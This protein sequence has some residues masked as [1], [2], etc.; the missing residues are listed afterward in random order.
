MQGATRF[1]TTYIDF[2]NRQRIQ[3][4]HVVGISRVNDPKNLKILNY[5]D[6]SLVW[7]CK[8]AD[9]EIDRMRK[10]A[11]LELLVPDLKAMPHFK[12]IFYNMQGLRSHLEDIKCNKNLMECDILLGA[13]TNLKNKDPDDMCE[14]SSQEHSFSFKRFN[15]NK[16]RLGRGLIVYCK[17]EFEVIDSFAFRNGNSVLEMMAIKT[18]AMESE[19]TII[20]VYRSP[21]YPFYSLK[22]N[23]EEILTIY[24]DCPNVLVMGDFNE[25]RN[26]LTGSNYIQI[27]ETSSTSG[28]FGGQLCHAYCCVSDYLLSSSVLF[29]CFTR[30]KHHPILVMLQKK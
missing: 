30:S 2:N 17:Q 18:T 8:E 5:F 29:R 11:N 6:P 23:L 4:A 9:A 15:N 3:N 21:H 22:K 7:K 28:L 10:E 14:I 1:S 19:L 20:N 13:E 24:S 16:E 27:I 25:E 26:V 12:I